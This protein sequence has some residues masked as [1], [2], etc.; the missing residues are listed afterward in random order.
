M[1]KH[2][3]VYIIICSVIYVETD[4][5]VG[6]ERYIE[7]LYPPLFSMRFDWISQMHVLLNEN[8]HEAE[9]EYTEGN[10]YWN[11]TN[12]VFLLWVK[13]VWHFHLDH[14]DQACW[15]ELGTCGMRPMTIQTTSVIHRIITRNLNASNIW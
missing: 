12:A 10:H 3:L 15:D 9:D 5:R 2:I 14:M 11:Y 1:N 6:N 7:T 13:A 4:N 8:G